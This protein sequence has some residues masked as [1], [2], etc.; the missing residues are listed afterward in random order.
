MV[1]NSRRYLIRKCD[2]S[3]SA[4]SLTP[5]R[6]F[7]LVKNSNFLNLIML[8]LHSYTMVLTFFCLF[9]PLKATKNLKKK[10]VGLRGVII[11]SA[12]SLTPRRR[13]PQCHWHLWGGLCGVIYTSEAVSAVSLTPL[14][15]SPRCQWHFGSGLHGVID[16]AETLSKVSMK[17]FIFF[18]FHYLNHHFMLSYIKNEI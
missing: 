7:F 16:T 5:W 3:V 15:R 18:C 2:F 11:D 14:R 13:S 8:V 17:I 10:T 9:I 12:V 4:V 1:S 6:P